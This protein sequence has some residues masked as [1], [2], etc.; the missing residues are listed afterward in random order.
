ML[1]NENYKIESDPLNII[2]YRKSENTRKPGAA[3]VWKA[4][5]YFGDIKE[6]L[7]KIAKMEIFGTGLPD[8][9]TVLKKQQE[10]YD[11]INSLEITSDKFRAVSDGKKPRKSAGHPA[12]ARIAA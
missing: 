1:I 4:V 9:K 6:A 5:G 11:L 7:E 2:I 3:P 10:I 8:L 12:E